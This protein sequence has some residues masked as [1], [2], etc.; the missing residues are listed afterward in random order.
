MIC[1]CVGRCVCLFVEARGCQVSFFIT[2][3]IPFDKSH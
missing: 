2:P 1:V 3:L